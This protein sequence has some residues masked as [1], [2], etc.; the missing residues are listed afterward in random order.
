[1]NDI[2]HLTTVLPNLSALVDHL[3]H[4][5]LEQPVPNGGTVHETL[6]RIIVMGTTYACWLR[7]RPTAECTPPLVY[8]WVPAAEFREVMD[9]LLAAL[10]ES[11]M[12][13]RALHTPMGTMTGAEVAHVILVGIVINGRALAAATDHP[14]DVPAE[15]MA[16]VDPFAA[17]GV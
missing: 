11:G 12:A 14:F 6:D 1:M 5:Q 3:W 2:D 15:V 8:G 10:G 17:T 16:A 7:G 4:G 13:E 9:D